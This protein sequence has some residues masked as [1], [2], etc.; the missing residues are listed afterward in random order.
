MQDSSYRIEILEKKEIKA[1]QN[2][3]E[4]YKFF[5][6]GQGYYDRCFER[7]SLQEI[8]IIIALCKDKVVGYV[9]LNWQPKYAYFKKLGIA[10]I[11]DLN[12]ISEFR[13]NGVGQSLVEFCE[14]LALEKGYSEIGIGV[15]LD[16]SFGAAQRIYARLGYIPDGQGISYDRKQITRG[17]FRPIDDNL[18]LMMTKKLK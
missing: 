4:E 8:E 18:C 9:L 7:Q 6:S 5:G 15:G 12:V 10:E 2:I 1:F 16:S 13:R 17:E 14:K 11:Q 3:I